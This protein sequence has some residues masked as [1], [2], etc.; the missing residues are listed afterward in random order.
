MSALSSSLTNFDM[1]SN[2]LNDQS[3]AISSDCSV[4]RPRRGA[5]ELRQS[6]MF[7]LSFPSTRKIQK[8]I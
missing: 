5:R 4:E 1:F 3:S 2:D 8:P 6:M 7:N